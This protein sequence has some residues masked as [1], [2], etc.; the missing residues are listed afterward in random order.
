MF[1]L[2]N[3]FVVF[4]GVYEKGMKLFEN[5][6]SRGRKE[7]VSL[8]QALLITVRLLHSYWHYVMTN[9]NGEASTR[10][11]RRQATLGAQ[12]ASYVPVCV[13]FVIT[14]TIRLIYFIAFFSCAISKEREKGFLKC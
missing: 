11:S 6:P 9:R 4:I 14:V 12:I 3:L 1:Q 5:I 7:G 2:F 13:A 8:L 10:P